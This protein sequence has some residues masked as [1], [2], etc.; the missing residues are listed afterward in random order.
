MTELRVGEVQ[1]RLSDR[2]DQPGAR[3]L[4]DRAVHLADLPD[5]PGRRLLWRRVDLGVVPRDAR[6][7]LLARRLAAHLRDQAADAVDLLDPAAADAEVVLAPDEATAAGLLLVRLLGGAA[8]PAWPWRR[9]VPTWTGAADVAGVL[10]ALGPPPV[11]GPG[12]ARAA[13]SL[14]V[15]ARHHLLSALPQLAPLAWWRA[16]CDA[17]GAPQPLAPGDP[18]SS[19]SDAL[20]RLPE[21]WGPPLRARL[22]AS[23]LQDPAAPAALIT[24]A[25]ASLAVARSSPAL[26]GGGPALVHATEALVE[27]LRV[28]QAAA[29]PAVTKPP[30]SPRPSISEPPARE[31][32][33]PP[34]PTSADPPPRPADAAPPL[35]DHTTPRTRLGGLLFLLPVLRRLGLDELLE[36]APEWL[37]RDLGAHTLR[38][39]A[40][41]AGLP[42]DDALRQALPPDEAVVGDLNATDPILALRPPHQAPRWVVGPARRAELAGPIVLAVRSGGGPP[43]W[44]EPV[45]DAAGLFAAGVDAWCQRHLRRTAAEI[46]ARPGAVVVSATHVDVLLPLDTVDVELRRAGLDLDP[47]WVPWWGRVVIYHYVAQLPP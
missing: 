36:A 22:S 1:L 29:R 21:G 2:R 25:L 28:P 9:A 4:I 5:R 31:A 7:E 34:S 47:G 18:P 35:A 10:S 40:D 16:T 45:P 24:R 46:A 43:P 19:P 23:A 12:R 32:E 14:D 44:P 8:V 41:L 17:L 37:L 42:D 30:P 20:S 6:P 39:L 15:V 33:Q 38:R 13:A 27:A 3:A 26:R 11:D